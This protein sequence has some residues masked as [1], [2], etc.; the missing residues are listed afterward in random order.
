VSLALFALVAAIWGVLL[1]PLARRGRAELAVW[2]PERDTPARLSR[3]ARPWTTAG[4]PS[5]DGPPADG[6]DP[7]A[8]EALALLGRRRAA[9]RRTAA[10]RR[11]TLLVLAVATAAGLR[12]W[13]ALGGRWWVAPTA[14]GG[15][16]VA[17]LAVLVGMA[18]RGSR[19]TLARRG[20]RPPRPAGREARRRRP[21]PVRAAETAWR[22]RATARW[23]VGRRRASGAPSCG[24]VAPTTE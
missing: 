6:P 11:R 23:R 8:A 19:A 2:A 20:A 17:Y 14:A 7:E 12:A 18:W 10:R 3:G 22:G 5:S 16:L 24:P 21:G 15:L 4:D 9:R 13:A 1:I